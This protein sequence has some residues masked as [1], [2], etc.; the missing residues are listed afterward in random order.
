MPV[1]NILSKEDME[2][3]QNV[4]N[5]AVF[6]ALNEALDTERPY[7][8]MGAPMPWSKNTRVVKT[9]QSEEYAQ[10]VLEKA[11]KKVIDWAKFGAGSK[12]APLPPAPT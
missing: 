10:S 6:E 12:I 8:T 9:N 5:Y 7:K 4:H 3:I 2:N 1:S 11:K